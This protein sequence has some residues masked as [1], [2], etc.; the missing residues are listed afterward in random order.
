MLRKGLDHLSAKVQLFYG[1]P[2]PGNAKASFAALK[3]PYSL[4]NP[5]LS[6]ALL[7]TFCSAPVGCFYSALDSCVIYQFYCYSEGDWRMG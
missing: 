7:A 4:A 5:R 2:S 1:T 6:F 3:K